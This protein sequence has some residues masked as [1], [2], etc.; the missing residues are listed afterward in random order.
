MRESEPSRREVLAALTG[1]AVGPRVLLPWARGWTAP[2]ARTVRFGAIADPH[3]G[4]APDAQERLRAFVKAVNARDSLD[5]V[6][7]LGDFCHPTEEGKEC[8]ALINRIRVPRYHVLGN[9]DMDKGSKVETMAHWGMRK[10]HYAL[11]VGGFR[12]VVLD[13]NHLNEGE[14]RVPYGNSNFYVD[15]KTRAWADEPQ[16][17]WLARTLGEAQKPTIVFSHQPLGLTRPGQP[18]PPQQ[19]EVFSIIRSANRAARGPGVIACVC[20]HLHVDRHEQR[21]G[22][23]CLCV[24]SASYFW[25]RG[26]HPYR[27]PLFAFFELDPAGVIR[28]EGMTSTWRDEKDANDKQLA[29]GLVGVEPRI[30]DRRLAPARSFKP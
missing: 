3:H 20:G 27:D 10:P 6:I 22:V 8:V 19:E 26:M 13:L 30:S 29:V 7:Q 2:G 23:H 9:H 17:R 11:D 16:L 14:R 18:L 4:L 25:R 15:G 1:L 21:D 5:F 28:V 12:F 24:N